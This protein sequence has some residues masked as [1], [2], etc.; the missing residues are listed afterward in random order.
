ME[1]TRGL[2]SGGPGFARLP[3][4]RGGHGGELPEVVGEDAPHDARAAVFEAFAARRRAHAAVGR[5]RNARLGRA[6]P[7]LQPA[8]ARIVLEP[9]PEIADRL[10]A[11]RVE[12]PGGFQTR[13]VGLG[14]NF[15]VGPLFFRALRLFRLLRLPLCAM[16]DALHTKGPAL[17]PPGCGRVALTIG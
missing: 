2:S 13:G 5:D 1:R 14:R 10:R 12:D 3:S 6:A 16:M 7:G 8:E 15:R 4:S 17:S 11:D 9:F